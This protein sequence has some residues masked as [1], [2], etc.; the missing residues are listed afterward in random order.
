MPEQKIT[1]QPS[2]S[3]Y[4]R[5]QGI[6]RIL[7]ASL[8]SCKGLKAAWVHEAAFRQEL[9]GTLLFLFPAFYLG[10]TH[11]ERAILVSSL[12]LIIIVE[13]LNSAIEAT[14]DRIGLEYHELSGRAKDFGSAAVLISILMTACVWG[15]ILL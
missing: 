5:I 12:F 8:N 6:A 14:V 10:D 7:K 9:Y 3:P 11:V 1:L 2:Q 13:L 15:I 4:K